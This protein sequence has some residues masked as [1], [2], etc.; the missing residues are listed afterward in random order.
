MYLYTFRRSGAPRL[1]YRPG[2]ALHAELPLR[3]LYLMSDSGRPPVPDGLA[4]L[5]S[6]R[7]LN[8][9]HRLT[10]RSLSET[11]PLDAPLEVICFGLDV[12][13][14]TG[15]RGLR[16]WRSLRTLWLSREPGELTPDDWSE[17][18]VLLEESDQQQRREPDDV[19]VEPVAGAELGGR[20]HGSAERSK[21]TDAAAPRDECSCDRE[22]DPDSGDSRLDPVQAGIAVPQR[23]R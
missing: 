20:E 14:D 10:G 5:T 12:L 6:L 16:H 8:V 4:R 19:E 7:E 3:G 15:M 18:A 9:G 2:D 23:E 17:V 22:Q 13:R 11:L 1:T 21:L